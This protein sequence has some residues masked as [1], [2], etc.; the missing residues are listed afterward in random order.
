MDETGDYWMHSV[1][2]ITIAI[3]AQ[4]LTPAC[5]ATEKVEADPIEISAIELH[6]AFR[7]DAEAAQ[8]S[9]KY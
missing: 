6:N 1:I 5:A 3:M 9:C 2:L 4:L 7:A 8:N